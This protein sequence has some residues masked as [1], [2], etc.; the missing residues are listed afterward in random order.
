MTEVTV[1][2]RDNPDINMDEQS[3]QFVAVLATNLDG[4]PM[5][6][7]GATV[8]WV[9][10]FNGVQQT[11]KD[12]STMLAMLD[13]APSTTVA[14]AVTLPSNALT[15]AKISGFSP[16]PND[17][18][19]TK[20]FAVGD[21]VNIIDTGGMEANTIADIDPVNSILTMV[22]PLTFAYTTSATV[23]KIITMFMFDLLPGDTILPATKAYGTQI[24]WQHMALATYP[25]SMSP[26]NIRALPTTLVPIRGRVF[27]NPILDMS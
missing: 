3:S 11:K 1:L 5:D 24:I 6:L 17:G 2:T 21:V 14:D 10:S 27:I 23:T 22:N 25:G 8:T 26:E 9:A 7:T 4:T 20:D 12:T 16:R 15:V 18:W 19:P 13:T